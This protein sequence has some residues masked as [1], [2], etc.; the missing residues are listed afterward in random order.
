MNNGII[1]ILE[2]NL[3]DRVISDIHLEE[4][5]PIY[6]REK[7]KLV[8]MAAGYSLTKHDLL[9]FVVA[10]RPDLSNPQK[11]LEYIRV[12]G[13]IDFSINIGNRYFRGHAYLAGRAKLCIALRQLFQGLSNFDSLNL[14]PMNNELLMLDSGLVLVCGQA[15]SGK[16]TTLAGIVE[17]KN[18]TEAIHVVTIEDP[19]EYTFQS[20]QSI[21]HQKQVGQDC[22]DFKTA[23]KGVLR[24]D[25]D[26][27]MIG[28]IRDAQA[29]RLALEAS[30]TGHLVIASLHSFN[31]LTCF[32]RVLSL[33][34]DSEKSWALQILSSSLRAIVAQKLVNDPTKA[35]PVVLSEILLNNTPDLSEKILKASSQKL[36]ETDLAL[37]FENSVRD[38]VGL[39]KLDEAFSK[40]I[41]LTL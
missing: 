32:N 8:P 4:A 5:K 7:G 36:V 3:A 21:I 22:P 35:H 20:K 30:S 24:E 1:R 28:E 23:L 25:P 13:E 11:A 41:K 17:H 34:D 39:G 40:S 19:I 27:I 38:L 12:T 15:G 10:E 33:L 16:S 31:S 14:H 2:E 26:L 6:L 29:M 37:T 18:L 9:S